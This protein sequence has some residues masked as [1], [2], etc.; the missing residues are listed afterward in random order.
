[1]PSFRT[2]TVVALLSERRGLQRVGVAFGD[3]G[4]AAGVQEEHAAQAAPGNDRAYVLTELTGPVSVGD[5]VVLNTTAI[6]LGLGSGGW[7][8]VHWNLS[9]AEWR[10]PGPGHVMKLRYTSLQV[11]TGTA[12]ELHA[13]TLADADHLEGMPVVVCGLHSQIPCVAV[14]LKHACPGLRLAYVMTDG[15]GLAIATSELVATMTSTGLLDVTVTAGHA[16]GG[17]HEAVNVPA[18]LAV[19]RLVGHA[20]AAVVGMGPGSVGTATRL[21]LSALEVAPALDAAESLG[22][23][24]VAAIRFSLADPR[25]RHQGVSH[26]SRTALGLLTRARATIGIPQGPFEARL[27]ADLEASGVADRHRLLAVIDPDVPPLLAEHGLRVTSMR[28]SPAD[29]PGF[30]AA[31]GA[32]GTAAALLVD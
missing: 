24:P 22:G 12:E 28:R 11:D 32:A 1:M 21:G 17:D 20:D 26:H 25:L 29:D 15:G 3:S 31:A 23:R 18:A 10:S 30:Y 8:V 7:H 19:A 5:Q 27:R 9:R 6:E 4:T 16:F 2:A 14:A 13:G